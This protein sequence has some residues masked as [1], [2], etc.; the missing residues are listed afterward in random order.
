MEIIRLKISTEELGRMD[1]IIHQVMASLPDLG[2]RTSHSRFPY[3][4]HHQ[5]YRTRLRLHG[6]RLRHEEVS[7]VLNRWAAEQ[8]RPAEAYVWQAIAGAILNLQGSSP[9]DLPEHI[10]LGLETVAH[11]KLFETW[12]KSFLTRVPKD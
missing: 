12:A 8:E 4:L 11:G 6:K 2:F 9:I 3:S 10:R 1:D 7:I 5:H